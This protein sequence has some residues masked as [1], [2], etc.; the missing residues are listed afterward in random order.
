MEPDIP[1]CPL[2]AGTTQSPIVAAKKHRGMRG[3][4]VFAAAGC[5]FMAKRLQQLEVVLL[6]SD[7]T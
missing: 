4:A 6:L 1:D 3:Y 7:F 2:V 5:E